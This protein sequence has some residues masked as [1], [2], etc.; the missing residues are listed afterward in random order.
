MPVTNSTSSRRPGPN[1]AEGNA[2]STVATALR[3][4]LD[5]VGARRV[6]RDLADHRA[7]SRLRLRSVLAGDQERTQNRSAAVGAEGWSRYQRQ[8]VGRPWFTWGPPSDRDLRETAQALRSL[9]DT[10]LTDRSG[11]DVTL[12]D[13]LAFAADVLDSV[14][15]SGGSGT[16]RAVVDADAWS[17]GCPSR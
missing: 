11:N 7:A 5:D 16:A 6:Q 1:C 4:T 9:A 3:V 14:A 2:P 15:R 8:Q 13:R 10:P 12:Q 17:T